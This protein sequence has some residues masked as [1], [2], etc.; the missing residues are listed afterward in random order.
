MDGAFWGG[1]LGHVGTFL[2]SLDLLGRSGKP[3]VRS[4]RPFALRYRSK[5]VR[6]MRTWIF[7]VPLILGWIEEMQQLC[8][9]AM[10]PHQICPAPL[11]P[12]IGI[13]ASHPTFRSMARVISAFDAWA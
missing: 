7:A 1:R 8:A 12:R 3:L 5:L 2:L 10:H 4:A 9:N 13:L 11:P 6:W